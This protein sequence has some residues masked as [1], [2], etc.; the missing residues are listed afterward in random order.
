MNGCRLALSRA[1]CGLGWS[2][3]LTT[4]IACTHGP[5]NDEANSPELPRTTPTS[6]PKTVGIGVAATSNN[7]GVVRTVEAATCRSDAEYEVLQHRTVTRRTGIPGALLLATG[8]AGT[9]AAGTFTGLSFAGRDVVSNTD[10]AYLRYGAIGTGVP[11]AMFLISGIALLVASGDGTQTRTQRRSTRTEPERCPGARMSPS[12]DVVLDVTFRA[13]TGVGRITTTT[14]GGGYLPETLSDR[15]VG[16]ASWC[17][18]V[19]ISAE[20]VLPS[21]SMAGGGRFAVNTLKARLKGDDAPPPLE[22]LDG[23]DQIRSVAAACCSTRRIA[24][25]R[26]RCTQACSGYLEVL[27]CYN[28]LVSC[29]TR[30]MRLQTLSKVD[31]WKVCEHLYEECN[32]SLGVR[33]GELSSC[34]NTCAGANECK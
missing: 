34:I 21:E 26:E 27:D 7:N 25:N 10:A 29:R 23:N 17:G 5:W 16:L 20:P 4:T 30:A 14:D 12:A 15:L 32:L 28:R 13:P 24:E 2:L 33:D 22:S 18:G 11:S 19:E 1:A 6:S 9:I 31:G 8:I 3:V